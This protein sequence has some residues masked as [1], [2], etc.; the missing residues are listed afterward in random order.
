MS[1][2][3]AAPT[4]TRVHAGLANGARDQRGEMRRQPAFRGA[5]RGT[6]RNDQQRAAT[7][8]SRA[9]SSSDLAS[10]MCGAGTVDDRLERTVGNPE[11]ANQVLVVRALMTRPA[12]P[13]DRPRQQ[14]PPQVG[15]ISPPIRSRA[16]MTAAHADA[17]E[18]G[19]R[20]ARS[21]CSAAIRCT[22]SA[23]VRR[24][25]ERAAPLRDDRRVHA[26]HHRVERR[27]RRSRGT[28]S[29]APPGRHDGCPPAPAAPSRRRQASSGATTRTRDSVIR[30]ATA[31]A[32]R[33]TG[34]GAGGCTSPARRCSAA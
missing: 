11:L 16:P 29:A 15:R 24:S 28:R 12:G 20:I 18:L 27:D 4:S 25:D 3:A 26:G 17:N 31:G 5:V 30:C 21:I 2:S 23:S 7:P 14:R 9:R 13:P 34:P 6:G 19:N 1:A 8:S 32:S 22:S 10:S 33:A